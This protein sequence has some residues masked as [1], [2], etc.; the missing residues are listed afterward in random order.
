MIEQIAVIAAVNG[1]H[2]I[3]EARVLLQTFAVHESRGQLAHER[4]F[5]RA[6]L[7]GI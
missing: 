5:L 6:K 7:C 3:K 4:F 1:A 2:G